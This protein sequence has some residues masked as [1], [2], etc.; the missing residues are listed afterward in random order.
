ME[1]PKKLR[2]AITAIEAY[3]PDYV[4]TNEELSTMVDTSDEWIMSCVGIRERR[5]L[6]GEHGMTFMAVKAVKALLE[7][8][9]FDPSE[10][11]QLFVLL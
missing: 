8:T 2:A 11:G 7:K 1:T 10:V 5:I 4:L 9:T 3:V 6:K